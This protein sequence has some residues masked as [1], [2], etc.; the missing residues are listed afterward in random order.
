MSKKAPQSGLATDQRTSLKSLKWR[1]YNG[2]SKKRFAEKW[3]HP[4]FVARTIFLSGAIHG[5]EPELYFFD[6]DR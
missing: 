4:W 6:A 3:R 1:R 5:S 2:F